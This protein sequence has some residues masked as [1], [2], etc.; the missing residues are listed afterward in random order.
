L[1]VNFGEFS[2]HVFRIAFWMY[3]VVARPLSGSI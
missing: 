1:I 2:R 3:A